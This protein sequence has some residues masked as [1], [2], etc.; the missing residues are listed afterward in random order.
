MT[1]EAFEGIKPH[2]MAALAEQHG[3]TRQH[4]LGEFADAFSSD[5]HPWL[6]VPTTTDIAD[7]DLRVEQFVDLVSRVSG[8]VPPAVLE[9][10]R[11]FSW[12]VIRF[13][14]RGADTRYVDYSDGRRLLV[15]THEIMIAI[16]CSLLHD[17]G[18]FT[19]ATK[20]RAGNWLKGM[21][22]DQ[23]EYGS[24][25]VKLLVP[26]D[27]PTLIGST[28]ADKDRRPLGR[29][30]TERLASALESTR[31]VINNPDAQRIFN[32]IEHGVSADFCDSLA[33]VVEPY[34]SVEAR[35]DWSASYGLPKPSMSLE[36]EKR[37]SATLKVTSKRI[38][39][40]AAV[41]R[42]WGKF[43][44][45]VRKLDRRV[46]SRSGVGKIQL[47]TFVD[48]NPA[49]VTC[50]LTTPDYERAAHAHERRLNVLVEG[51][52]RTVGN[53]Q[54][55]LECELI[56]VF[57]VAADGHSQTDSTHVAPR[58]LATS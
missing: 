21:K 26:V 8:T 10:L 9:Q 37:E 48:G 4:S 11:T 15:G 42:P 27:Q 39:E 30:I 38:R 5:D 49:T 58:L 57:E 17:S 53:Q 6:V 40:A 23:T 18:V 13:R 14:A 56:S 7:Y 16:A 34:E 25:V 12:D 45:Y 20:R 3:W 29:R 1:T 55:L 46:D 35:L 51:E 2:A 52:L 32:S 31:S 50:E 36:F 41:T 28:G 47:E 33:K 54:I 43:P 24:Y 44:G 19:S 22:L